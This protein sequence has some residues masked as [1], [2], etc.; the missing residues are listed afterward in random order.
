[1][2]DENVKLELI[3]FMMQNNFE[4]FYEDINKGKNKYTDG[5]KH[6]HPDYDILYHEYYKDNVYYIE[7]GYKNNLVEFVNNKY[8]ESGE[9][10]N[11]AL[12][13]LKSVLRTYKLN[14]ILT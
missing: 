14:N 3:R 9:S 10:F 4:P 13:H 5:L 11:K 12:T 1:M 2:K 6:K 7:C 8:E